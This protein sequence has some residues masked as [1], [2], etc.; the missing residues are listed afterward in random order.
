MILGQLGDA[1][2]LT[3]PNPFEILPPK[4]NPYGPG[5]IQ[6]EPERAK[7]NPFR[8]PAMAVNAA[9]TFGVDRNAHPFVYW[10]FGPIPLVWNTFMLAVVER[11]P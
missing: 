9:I 11:Q 5:G 8:L 1:L 7:P 3:K 2:V 10:M 4:P 6:I